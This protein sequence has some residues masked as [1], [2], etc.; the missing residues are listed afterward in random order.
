MSCR[1]RHTSWNL[2]FSTIISTLIG[3]GQVLYANPP[4]PKPALKNSFWEVSKEL[5]MGGSHF[6]YQSHENVKGV[7]DRLEAILPKELDKK[8]PEGPLDVEHIKNALRRLRQSSGLGEI[9]GR[10]SSSFA[11]GPNLY[12]NKNFTHH[13]PESNQGILWKLFGTK[14]HEQEILKLLPDDTAAVFHTD[15]AVAEVMNWM[16]GFLNDHFP[17][18]AQSFNDSMIPGLLA[19]I[20]PSY[21]GE[22]G[23]AL[24]LDSEANLKIPDPNNFAPWEDI[25]APGLLLSVKT[26][27]N[28]IYSLV[29]ATLQ[30]MGI[31]EIK[32][33]QGKEV[34]EIMLPP[35][36]T[37]AYREMKLNIQPVLF[38]ANGYLMLSTTKKI[39]QQVLAVQAGDQAGLLANKEFQRFAKNLNLEGNQITYVSERASRLPEELLKRIGRGVANASMIGAIGFTLIEL[40]V[41][42]ALAPAVLGFTEMGKTGLSILRVQTNGIAREG[43]HTSGYNNSMNSFSLVAVLGGTALSMILP[44]LRRAK[45]KAELQKKE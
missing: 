25:P 29:K 14:P 8:I 6:K 31:A 30:G 24:V 7:L 28:L 37:E 45:E 33:I 22:I 42:M 32:Q 15:L 38:E 11:L 3:M 39:A 19:P 34:V 20:L 17:D 41:V 40:V 21:G 18:Q 10:G 12:R 5:D 16:K 13:Y 2:L 35:D 4:S 1:P 27:N 44:A 26:K 43:C 36:S 23:V 9:S